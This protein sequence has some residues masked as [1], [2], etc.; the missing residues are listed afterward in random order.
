VRK[1]HLSPEL[2]GEILSNFRIP[3]GEYT[4]VPYGSG[5]INDTLLAGNGKGDRYIFQRINNNIFQDIPA[6]MGN[7]LRVTE[8]LQD[9]VRKNGGDPR[10]ESLTVIRTVDNAPYYQ[11]REGGYWRAYLFV[12]DTVC[13]DRAETAEEFA[14]S[15]EAFG[16]FQKLLA[17]FPADSLAETI[18]DFH[19]TPK[20]FEAFL[21]AIQKDPLG[22]KK[23]V[24]R[25]IEFLLA[26]REDMSRLTEALRKGELPLRVTHNDTKLNNV[27][28]DRETLRGICVIDLDTVMPGLSVNDFGDSIRFG[29]S[30]APEDEQDLSKV[31]MSLSLFRAYAEG[32]LRGCDGRLTENEYACL[33]LGAKTMT[34]ECG[35]RFLTDYLLGDTY[36]KTH[37][38][39]QNLD[40]CRTQ[41]K[42]V[43]DMEG[44]WAE[45]ERIISEC[46]G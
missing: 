22:R 4:L 35:M 31:E 20:R 34:M 10:R 38:P 18:P 11:D 37:R 44:K 6:L 42:L 9:S 23:E 19:N 33:P 30:T 25:E 27:L 26:R 12:E 2:E 32:F 41:L 13:R 1:N 46:R 3:S 40:R 14:Q 15:G 21:D 39:G 45:M 7:I 8:F 5:H 36:F 43:A 28:L 16:R 17:D 29:A 24:E